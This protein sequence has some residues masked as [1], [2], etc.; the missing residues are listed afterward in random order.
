[1]IERKDIETIVIIAD[2]VCYS[3]DKVNLYSREPDRAI[4]SN[5]D[6]LITNF[7]KIFKNVVFYDNPEHFLSNISL[8]KRDIIFPYWHGEKSRNKQA[9]IPSICE[10]GNLIY[11]G[12]D[13]YTN[14]VCCDKILSKDICRLANIK[15]P[16]HIVINNKISNIDLSSLKFPILIKPTYE[17]TSIGITQKNLF[18]KEDKQ[19]II[20]R[21]NI[22]YDNLEQPIIIEEFIGGKE[23]SLSIIGWNDRI[24]AWGAVERYCP[25]ND[26]YFETNLHSFRD[27][28]YNKINLREG[29]YLMPKKVLVKLFQL[30]KWLDKVE[31]LRIDGKLIDDVFYCFEL[32]HDTTFNPKGAFFTPFYYE[33]YDYLGV[34]ELLVNNCLERYNNQHP[35]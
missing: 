20:N 18:F 33:G 14:I 10:A 32:S 25:D 24:K 13:T 4:K 16:K 35:N 5:V 34:L 22:L 26:N 29:N 19:S 15:T 12:G 8:H 1:M 28:L 9:L 30:F 7:S 21:I 27:K 3:K 11:I 17:G 6:S 2:A 23:I 31:Y